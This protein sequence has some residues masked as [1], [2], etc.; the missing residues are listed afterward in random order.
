VAPSQDLAADYCF[1]HAADLH[2]DTPFSGVGE[3]APAV[4]AALREASLD[5][6]NNLVDLCLDRDA[7]FLVI[8]GDIYDRRIRLVSRVDL[9][10]SRHD[11]RERDRGS[12]S[13]SS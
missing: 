13:G 5:A 9:A 1:V 8:A 4:A 2:L 3:T 11:L 12:G 6:F 10:P 7:A